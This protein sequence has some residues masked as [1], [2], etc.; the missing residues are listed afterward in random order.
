M[1]TDLPAFITGLCLGILVGSTMF[2]QQYSQTT[3][4]E[5]QLQMFKL[6]AYE[7]GYMVQCVGKVGYYWGCE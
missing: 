4:K 2:I 7:R 5:R 3:Q 1:R 6:E